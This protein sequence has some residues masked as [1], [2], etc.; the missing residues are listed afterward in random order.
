M[1]TLITTLVVG[2]AAG[3]ALAQTWPTRPVTLLVPF[4]PAAPPT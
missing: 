4:P 1:R 2:L 3:G